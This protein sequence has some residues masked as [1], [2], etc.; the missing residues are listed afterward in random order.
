MSPREHWTILSAALAML[1]AVG[2]ACSS[3]ETES[4]V[5]PTTTT[6]AGTGG[7][8]TGTGGG[9]AG[10]GG[11]NGCEGVTCSSHGTC[12]DRGGEPA[13]D[14]DEGYVALALECIEPLFFDSFESGDM[15]AT[16]ADG[17]AWG[18]N[19]RT[20]V[21]TADAAVWN[22]GPID[23]PIPDG[24]D[25]T[26][27]HGDH[28]LRFRYPALEA[29]AEQRFDMGSAY[30]EIWIRYFLRIPHNF[31]HEN[32]TGSSANN[33][34]FAL[35]VD[36]Y[37]QH[38]EGPTIVWNFWPQDD[39]S[40]RFTYSFSNETTGVVG[41]HAGYDDFIRYP[42]DQGRWMQVLLYA[43]MSSSATADDGETR[44]WRRWE[45]EQDYTLIAES[46]ERGFVEP[47]AGPAGWAAGYVMGWSNSGYA[48]DTEFLLDEFTL[49]VTSLLK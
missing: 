4:V 41:H 6:P 25:W 34:F 19:N 30:P 44:I 1:I 42:D 28:C 8:Q 46:L 36:G 43:K 17:F 37:S 20:S 29:W 45:G 24:S 2:N 31:I 7:G 13:C 18:N 26:P 15:S 33:K 23:N 9:A 49:S 27:H 10:G 22:N 35:W 14:C 48:E 5:V 12:V 32:P 3:D 40:S 38:G 47:A 39:G 16:N 21:V 11:S